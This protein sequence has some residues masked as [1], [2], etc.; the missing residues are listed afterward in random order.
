MPRWLF[1]VLV[2]AV[3]QLLL[4][5]F[6]RSLR[7]L[8]GEKRRRWLTATVFVAGDGLSLLAFSRLFPPLF[9]AQ[10]WL[11]ALL[12]LWFMAAVAGFVL[13]RCARPFAPEKAATVLRVFLP[14]AFAALFAWGFFNA[15]STVVR[16]YAVALDKPMAQPLRIGVATD[17]HLDSGFFFG[18]REL[19]RL[20]AIFAAEQVDIILLPG[21]IINDKPEAF[22]AEGMAPHLQALRA[23]LGVFGTLGNHEFYGDADENA[24]ALREGGVQ[25]LRDAVVVGE[26]AVVVGRDD[27]MNSARPPLAALLKD[28]R[29][30]LPVLVLDHR[31]T[32]IV[33]NARTPMDI[34]LSGHA[35]NGQVFPANFI[36]RA[37][38]RL[39][40][41][42]EQIEGKEIFV[43]SGYGFWGVPLRLG[44]RSEVLVIDV[45][46]RK[47]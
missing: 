42:H 33:G 24:R 14:T 32:E 35:H 47:D 34:Q 44:S 45:T 38:Y 9:I 41:G 29:R 6:A 11:L 37:L 20:A 4:W 16:H 7:F 30:D 17:L 1:A 27:D 43:S 13:Y 46:G 19:D 26:R 18:A 23:P 12:W 21:D 36:V 3:L 25:V 31:P 10:A 5:V 28:V 2:L 22:Y 15:N 39:H 40:Y 8:A